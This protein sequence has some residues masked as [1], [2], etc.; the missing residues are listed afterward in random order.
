MDIYYIDTVE[1]VVASE[2]SEYTVNEY[3][4]REQWKLSFPSVQAKYFKKL[5]DV[6]AD[7]IG[8]DKENA[9]HYYM[10]IQIVDSEDNILKEEKLGEKQPVELK[11]EPEPE[12]E[13]EVEEG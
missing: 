4:K 1:Q 7:L 8:G 13:N 12:P 2:E 9:K 10:N 3:G 5:S 11:P 6:S